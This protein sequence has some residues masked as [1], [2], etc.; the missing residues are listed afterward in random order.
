M[1]HY[2]PVC[3]LML[4]ISSTQRMKLKAKWYFR[5]KSVLA[6]RAVKVSLQSECKTTQTFGPMNW[7][8]W[9]SWWATLRVGLPRGSCLCGSRQRT[10]AVTH[11]FERSDWKAAS[12]RLRLIDVI[13]GTIDGYFVLVCDIF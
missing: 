12:V 6:L 4:D 7:M 3:R 5:I 1:C 10:V 2:Q 8:L 11:K 9:P 13:F